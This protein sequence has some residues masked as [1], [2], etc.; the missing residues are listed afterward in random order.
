MSVIMSDIKTLLKRK[1]KVV[2]IPPDT[3]TVRD[4]SRRAAA[5][6]AACEYRGSVRIRSR[7]GRS[8]V[9]T[10]EVKQPTP[11]EHAQQRAVDIAKIRAHHEKMKAMGFVAPSAKEQSRI[12]RWMAG[13]DVD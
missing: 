3:F 12:D 1:P 11:D 7:N 13:E 8:F 10:P 2:E 9:L 6:I 5:V 4:M